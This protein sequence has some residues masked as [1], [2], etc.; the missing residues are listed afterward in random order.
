M[1]KNQLSKLKSLRGWGPKIV[2]NLLNQVKSYKINH[3]LTE[4]ARFDD[5]PLPGEEHIS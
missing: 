2:E 5:E 4:K 1:S 3:H